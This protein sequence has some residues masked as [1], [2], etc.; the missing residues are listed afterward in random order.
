MEGEGKLSASQSVPGSM[1]PPGS[2]NGDGSVSV[3]LPAVF[4][5]AI[6]YTFD[7]STIEFEYDRTFWSA[8]EQLDFVY[9]VDLGHPIL[10]Q[11]FDNPVAK[12]W[13][14][15]N[16][17][18]IGLTYL[19]SHSFTLMVGGGIDGNPVPDSTISFD[20]PDSDAWFASLGFRYKHS[21]KLSYGAAYLYADKDDR[22]A[23]DD[24]GAV[25]GTFSGASTHL[26][27]GSFTY[28]F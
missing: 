11:A 19:W 13:D 28:R 2:Y 7:R 14:D 18:R 5:A 3:P 1:I 8:Y 20:L 24:T 26:I 15:V 9:P 23:A 10:T 6:A 27:T 12:D 17:Y 25:S 16:A 22:T 21:E 4:A